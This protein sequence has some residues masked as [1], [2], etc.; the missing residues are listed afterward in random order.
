MAV[1]TGTTEVPT[2]TFTPAKGGILDVVEPTSA[3]GPVF[4]GVQYETEGGA[5]GTLATLDPAECFA[6]ADLEPDD[7]RTYESGLPFVVARAITC[8]TVGGDMSHAEERA[9]RALELSE[10]MLVEKH[11]WENVFP[12]RAV[13]LTPALGAVTPKNGVGILLEY[14]G[15]NYTGMP[16]IHFGRRLG[17]FLTGDDTVKNGDLLAVN[18]RGYTSKL[19]P[20]IDA[21][22]NPATPETQSVAGVDEVWMYVTGAVHLWRDVISTHM[23]TNYTNNEYLVIA[24]RTYVATV[25]TF[26]AGIRVGLLGASG[27]YGQ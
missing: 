24:D 6:L 16:M 9:E 19:G 10:G 7:G 23:T 8:R 21:D 27:G 26:I 13:D 4:F 12:Q 1:L 20:F 11:L 3:S 25:E 22:A 15:L 14:A 5:L 2:P 17:V 18:G